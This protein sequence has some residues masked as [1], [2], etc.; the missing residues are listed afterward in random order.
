M[1]T[2]GTQDKT[3]DLLN[4]QAK[5]IQ[6]GQYE[7][8]GKVN[9]IVLDPGAQGSGRP[10]AVVGGKLGLSLEF[11][12]GGPAVGVTKDGGSLLLLSPITLDGKPGPGR[13]PDMPDPGWS[14][15]APSNAD[16]TGPTPY[17]APRPPML[18]QPLDERARGK[19]AGTQ[20]LVFGP[21]SQIL[22]Y[23]PHLDVTLLAFCRA[24]LRGMQMELLVHGGTGEAF[25]IGGKFELS[26][27]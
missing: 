11:Y 10:I 8:L 9:K 20:Y 24:D 19:L 4:W 27:I 6:T 17:I 3:I 16:L 15:P 12:A 26:R 22:I 14:P 21:I 5:Q 25:L 23:P 13:L 2:V 7:F 1:G 18:K